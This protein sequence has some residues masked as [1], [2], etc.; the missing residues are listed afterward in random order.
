MI[1]SIH[2]H[3]Q[4]QQQG[5]I[6]FS[7][8]HV[9]YDIKDEFL[10][11]PLM[12]LLSLYPIFIIVA[13]TTRFFI[14]RDLRALYLLICLI[15][16]SILCSLLKKLWNEPRPH[17]IFELNNHGTG[18]PLM[19]DGGMPSNHACFSALCSTFSILF[20]C[21]RYN[22]RGGNGISLIYSIKRWLF[23][24]IITILSI[25]CSFS[26]IR[27]EY[28]TISQVVVGYIVGSIFGLFSFVVYVGPYAHRWAG[29]WERI[30]DGIRLDFRSC[31]DVGDDVAEGWRI[32]IDDMRRRKRD[33]ENDINKSA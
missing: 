3:K 19:E 33:G 1:S 17:V 22:L 29:C 9:T 21:F 2:H 7:P 30:S 18:L 23:P 20:A 4:H 32:Y 27:L 6:P 25:G 5:R 16:S 14:G 12:G 15:L 24:I 26:R 8:T 10:I 13:L 31:H 11:G 28:H